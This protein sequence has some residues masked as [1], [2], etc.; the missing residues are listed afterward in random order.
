MEN[1]Q[2]VNSGVALNSWVE[3]C[4]IKGQKHQIKEEWICGVGT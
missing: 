3:N 1:S 2:T 4:E